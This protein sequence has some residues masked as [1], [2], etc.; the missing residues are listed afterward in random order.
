MLPRIF[1][2]I[3][4]GNKLFLQMCFFADFIQDCI[5]EQGTT[6]SKDGPEGS[7]G[8]ARDGCLLGPG[9]PQQA[10]CSLC[11]HAGTVQS[12]CI[13]QWTQCTDADTWP[14]RS[15]GFGPEGSPHLQQFQLFHAQAHRY[16]PE[17]LAE[18][19]MHLIFNQPQFLEVIF[20]SLHL[21]S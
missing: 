15:E 9:V 14:H 5:G 1:S 20:Y 3:S 13:W 21:S 12:S 7:H 8:A 11:S 19:E 18:K 10:G 17:P 16:P 4:T 2:V 6:G